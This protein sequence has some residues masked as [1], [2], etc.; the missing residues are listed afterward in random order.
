MKFANGVVLSPSLRWD[1]YKMTTSP[2]QAYANSGGQAVPSFS[3]SA[4]SPKLGLSIPFAGHYTAFAQL[5][6]GFRAPPFDDANMAFVNRAHGYQV[7]VNPALKSETSR[8][9]ELGLKGQWDSVDFGLTA[10]Q[11]RYR[12]F[13]EQ[14][15]LG[16]VNGL[17]TY[18]YQN[19]GRVDIKGAEA[20]AAWR[21]APGWQTHAAVAYTHGEDLDSH[22]A[23]ASVAPMSAVLGL[24]YGQAR[25]G[26]EALLRAAVRNNRAPAVALPR[27]RPGRPPVSRPGLRD[28]GPDRLLEAGQ[29]HHRARRRVQHLRP[30]ILEDRRRARHGRR[31]SGAG[32]LHPARPQRQRQRRIPILI[33]PAGGL[34]PAANH[35]RKP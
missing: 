19:I 12:D 34:P 17:L 31:R 8:G 25:F 30:Q 9:V 21:F 35:R 5:S 26:G 28:A 22:T 11:N 3:D 4:F 29:G 13:I 23:L 7:I 1:H 27:L 6:S 10:Y 16:M 32:P 24:R 33:H 20:R 2:D 15:S 14:Q 18:Q